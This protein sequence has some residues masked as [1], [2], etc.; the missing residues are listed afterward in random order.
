[1]KTIAIIPA[2][3]MGKRL[4]ANMAKQYLKLNQKPILV[5]T[6]QVFQESQIIDEI[7]L[8]LPKADLISAGQ[9][10]RNKYGLNK[11]T[12]IVAGGNERQDSV[13]NGLA[14]IDNKCDLVL[15]HD[16]VRPF[17]TE[18]M[19]R[20]VIAAAKV[21][22]AASVGVKAKETIKEA[23]KD[24]VVAITIP[25]NNIW[26]TQTPQAFKLEILKKA[27]KKACDEK[28]YGTDDASLVERMGIKVKMVAGSYDNIK[29]TT[30]ED[31]EMARALIR[32]KS[33]GKMK[34]RIGCGYDS[35]RFVAGRK[36][37]LGGVK[38]PFNLGLD[39]HSDADALI[40]AICDALFGAA[41]SG[42]IGRH[43]PDTD[44]QYK[45]ISSKVILG[46]VRKIIADEGFIINNIDAT[47]IMEKPKVAPFVD[48]I[49]NNIAKVLNMS[50]SDIN[51]KAKTNEGMGFV[52]RC[53]GIAVTAV[54]T[55]SKE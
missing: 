2:G 42:D 45:N 55:L 8:V 6:L 38:I 28:F 7:I 53:E 24:N 13:R 37:I 25:R 46:R 22:G 32:N 3:G 19:I 51:I 39:G 20:E 35:H 18:R 9:E 36:L 47:I 12:K 5:N 17:I 49:I 41:G 21:T 43:F 27:Y 14:A 23:G 11:V 40:H 44:P 26:L 30:P 31:L 54:A 29:I 1:M 15:V 10:L 48:K 52:G 16:A 4:K 50:A 34:I 33:G